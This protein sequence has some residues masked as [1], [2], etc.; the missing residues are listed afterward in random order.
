[1]VLS[2][3][4]AEVPYPGD[5]HEPR[6]GLRERKRRALRDQLTDAAYALVEQRGFEAATVDAIAEAADVSRTTAFRHF[7]TKEDLLLGWLDDVR[8]RLTAELQARPPGEPPLAAVRHALAALSA[9]YVAHRERT[10]RLARLAAGRPSVRARYLER[11]ARWEE[12]IAAD[13]ARRLGVD[14]AADLRPRLVAQSALAGASAATDLW[15]AGGGR[16]DLP[17]LV[18]EALSLLEAGLGRVG[19]P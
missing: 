18:D 3:Q 10:L 12:L 8:E 16:G 2:T 6:P 1:M 4:R 15:L 5:V 19:A 11:K 14:A 17:A 9:V 7:P 13:V